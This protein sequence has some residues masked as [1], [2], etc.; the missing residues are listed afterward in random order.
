MWYPQTRSNKKLSEKAGRCPPLG[1]APS[2]VK[3]KSAHDAGHWALGSHQ[4]Y[5]R[6]SAKDT[7]AL[8]DK[9][10]AQGTWIVN[11]ITEC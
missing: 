6:G 1:G 5:T 8:T 10:A 2:R 4:K 11:S 3:K 9:V 7:K